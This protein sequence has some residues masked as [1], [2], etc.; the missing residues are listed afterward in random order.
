MERLKKVLHR[1]VASGKSD[2]CS[3]SC[4]S[5]AI[6]HAQ[7]KTSLSDLGIGGS[8]PVAERQQCSCLVGGFAHSF[9]AACISRRLRRKVPSAAMFMSTP[10]TA[11][12]TD[13]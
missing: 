5:I 4:S 11:V 7:N 2:N 6:L 8:K 12:R 13:C 9:C 1:S 3:A 10:H